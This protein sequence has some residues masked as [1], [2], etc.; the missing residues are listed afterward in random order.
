MMQRRSAPLCLAAAAMLHSSAAKA[1]VWGVDPVLGLTTDYA[2]NPALLELRNTAQTDAAV[3]FD[4]PTTFNANDFKFS[5]LPSFRVGDTKSY[6]SVNSDYEHLTA[7]GELDTERSVFTATAGVTRDSS[8]YQ[9]YLANGESG[10]RR[11]GVAADLNWDRLLTER[12][13]F[14]TDLNTAQVR[15]GSA[16][17]TSSLVD[18]KYTS[19]GPTLIWN[20]TERAKFTLNASAGQY[21]SLDGTT[22]SRNENLQ[23]GFV[24]PLT[25]IWSV[26]ATGGFSHSQDRLALDEY[27]VLTPEGIGIA[28]APMGTVL[29]VIP[30]RAESTQNGAVYSV[31]LTRQGEQLTVNAGASRQ[32]T[33]SGFAF[34]SRQTSFALQ[35]NYALSAR[36]SFGANASY[37]DSQDPQVEDGQVFDRHVDNFGLNASWLWTEHWTLTLGASRISERVRAL[38]IDLASNEIGVTVSRKFDHISFFQ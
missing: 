8:L 15:Y 3:L 33:P 25:E 35:A 7:K 16:V 29:E 30:V 11:D 32:E 20:A 36:W 31:N 1:G 34:L 23:L 6:S 4:A 5:V 24:R 14:S 9:N 37:L 19:L 21:D 18:Y 38:H 13:D 12:I 22:R 17:G 28:T 27:L 2:T 26:T 10:V